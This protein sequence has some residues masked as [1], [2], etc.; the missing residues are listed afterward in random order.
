[1]IAMVS[2]LV[3]KFYKT[4]YLPKFI[5]IFD[6]INKYNIRKITICHLHLVGTFTFDL[7]SIFK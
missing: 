6:Y 4:S 7:D 1:M 2:K 3:A 5:S